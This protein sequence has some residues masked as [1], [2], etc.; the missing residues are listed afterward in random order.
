[1][2]RGIGAVVPLKFSIKC[3]DLDNEK[4]RNYEIAKR[5]HKEFFNFFDREKM[6]NNYVFTIKDD[7]LLANYCD[8]LLEFYQLIGEDLFECAR[9]SP[10]DDLLKIKDMDSFDKAFDHNARGGLPDICS[11]RGMVSVLGCEC[12]GSWLFYFGSYKAYLE[13]YKTFIHFERI[14]VKAMR[15]PLAKVVK[16]CEYG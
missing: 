7:F 4:S 11:S 9:I 1:M 2:G 12:S 5:F 10:G 15:N 16:F 14:L 13:V 6:D 3:W 8:F